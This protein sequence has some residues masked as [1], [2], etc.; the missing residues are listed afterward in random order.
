MHPCGIIAKC[1]VHERDVHYVTP[2][3]KFKMSQIIGT[4]IKRERNIPSGNALCFYMVCYLIECS[5][6]TTACTQ[7]ISYVPH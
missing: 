2:T 4:K 6:L 3:G 5:L 1:N 7:L